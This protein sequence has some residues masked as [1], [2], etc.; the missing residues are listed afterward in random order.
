MSTVHLMGVRWHY[1]NLF[2]FAKL[3]VDRNKLNFQV[4][5]RPLDYVM[6]YEILLLHPS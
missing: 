6:L 4:T 2:S 1:N 3:S 5:H